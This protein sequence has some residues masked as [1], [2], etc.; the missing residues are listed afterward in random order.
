MLLLAL[1]LCLTLVEEDWIYTPA[2]PGWLDPWVYLGYFLNLPQHLETFGGAYYGNR[3]GWVIPGFLVYSVLPALAANAVLHLSVFYSSVF[4]AYLALKQTLG[5]RVAL[6]PVLV[7]GCYSY[8][9][10]AAGWDYPD[11][12]ANAYFLLACVVIIRLEKARD[13]RPGAWIA[14]GLI[15]AMIHTHIFWVALTPALA[16]LML[17][18]ARQWSPARWFRGGAYL[19]GG[20]VGTTALLGAANLLL[21]GQFLFFA[22]SVDF[23]TSNILIPNPYR[24]P[25]RSWIFRA[26]WLVLPVI[27][28]AGSLILVAVE[29]RKLRQ[30]QL[31]W[32]L[33][34]ALQFLV[35]GSI[36]TAFEVWFVPAF[37][38][39]YYASCLI[40]S[41]FLALGACLHRLGATL[42]GRIYWVYI[43]GACAAMLLPFS[44]GPDPAT[45]FALQQRVVPL[46]ITLASLAA[47]A[48]IVRN[49]RFRLAA[50]F[51]FVVVFSAFN[52]ASTATSHFHFGAYGVDA[53]RHAFQLVVGSS[54]AVQEIEPD[55]NAWFWYDGEAQWTGLYAGVSSTYLWGY[56]LIGNYFPKIS[57]H[58][59]LWDG[60]T[61]ILLSHDPQAAAIATKTLAERGF[62][63]RVRL[64]RTVVKG[65]FSMPM[66]FMDLT[67]RPEAPE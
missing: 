5:Q 11:G 9:L 57:E 20:A 56:R 8:F 37:Q 23:A 64:V 55:G 65:Q 10:F 44:L 40:P 67:E 15:A 16:V 13:E 29:R 4:S 58:A 47:A 38:L 1:P 43:A 22:P 46:A 7:M 14:G 66:I 31:D 12:A 54:R 34:L 48:M 25:Y 62:D 3:I 53:K 21:G 30:L 26:Y 35:C 63:A 36:V 39:T 27:A 59:R 49:R 28:Y 45:L 6:L 52:I 2:L 18:I 50:V 41:S 42:H 51:G 33:A 61:V 24:A 32:P 17:P 19:I 60:Q